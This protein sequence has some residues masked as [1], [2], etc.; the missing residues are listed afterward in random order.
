MKT[1]IISLLFCLSL[2]VSAQAPDSLALPWLQQMARANYP[3]LQQKEFLANASEIRIGQIKDTWL[4]KV[5]IN[6]QASYQSDVTE[7]GISNPFFQPPVI[8]K[9]IE[10]INLNISQV[11]FDGKVVRSQKALEAAK[12]GSEQ[13]NVEIQLYQIKEK[14]NQLFFALV[15][16]DENRKILD[17]FHED[18]ALRLVTAEAG[19]SNGVLLESLADVI[20]AEL[21][22]MEQKIMEMDDDRQSALDL[23]S[24][25]TGQNLSLSSKLALPK[26]DISRT[27]GSK[28]MRPELLGFDLQQSQLEAAKTLANTRNIPRISAFGEAGYGKPGYN[29]FNEGFDTYYML[30]AK[31]SWN[32][33]DWGQAGKEKHILSFQQELVH[34]QAATFDLSTKIGAMKQWA[35]VQKFRDIMVKDNEIIKL[36]ERI[37]HSAAAQ[38]DN[39]VMTSTDYLIELNQEIQARLSMETHR[40]QEVKARVD[41]LTTLGL[42]I[43]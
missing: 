14:I 23:L 7:L 38:F 13:Q 39:G 40:L 35:E 11:L 28:S 29:M 24:L 17:K 8:D 22:K 31:L 5:D 2:S 42:D 18:L 33:W 16:F 37:S 3:L 30:G 6:A 9:D 36:R 1:W 12:L 32:L 20:R 27:A 21:I 25:W 43:Q 41:L 15:F 34:S 4:P 10:K 19:V 26:A